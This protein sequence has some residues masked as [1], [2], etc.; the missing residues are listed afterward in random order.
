MKEFLDEVDMSQYHAATAV[1]FELEAIKR[2]TGS[3]SQ[4]VFPLRLDVM[5]KNGPLVHILWQQ[6][7]VVIPFISND[8]ATCETSHWDY[9]CRCNSNVFRL[10]RM[11]L[12]YHF[13]RRVM[14]WVWEREDRY[15]HA[16]DVESTGNRQ[17]PLASQQTQ[18][19]DSSSV[20]W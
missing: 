10:E 15:K 2:I 1:S 3:Q 18:T 12:S 8:L 20:P 7:E 17:Y 13:L 19:T 4:W 9:L 11:I 14:V 6:V 16:H 5:K